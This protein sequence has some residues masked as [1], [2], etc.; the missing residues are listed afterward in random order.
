M[1]IASVANAGIFSPPDL[2]ALTVSAPS[3]SLLATPGLAQKLATWDG[4]M[5]PGSQ[6]TTESTTTDSADDEP[7]QLT[8]SFNPFDEKTWWTDAT[9][10]GNNVDTAA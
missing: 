7:K 4:G 10:K 8:Y 9:T 3:L 5:T 1:D 2:S 6:R